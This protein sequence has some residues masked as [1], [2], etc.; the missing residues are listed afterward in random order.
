[1]ITK[2]SL[3]GIEFRCEFFGKIKATTEHPIFSLP[4]TNLLAQAENWAAGKL[5]DTENKLLF[6]ALLKST[7]LVTFSNREGDKAARI[8]PSSQIIFQNMERLMSTCTWISPYSN[9]IS[10]PRF[11]I[12][13][14]NSDLDNI[15]NILD[16][17]ANAKNQIRDNYIAELA[18]E[19]LDN[20][21]V[22]LDRLLQKIYDKPKTY[23][24]IL[25]QWALETANAPLYLRDTWLHM[26]SRTNKS[27]WD[28]ATED[29]EL[30]LEFFETSPVFMETVS[31][32]S[33]KAIATLQH[34]RYL[35]KENQEGFLGSISSFSFIEDETS[36]S[37]LTEAANKVAELTEF[38]RQEQY[39]TKLDFIR[40]K[41]AWQARE[42]LLSNQE[43]VETKLEKSLQKASL[44]AIDNAEDSEQNNEDD[45]NDAR[46]I[47]GITSE[48]REDSFL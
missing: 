41:I 19:Q 3:T 4:L 6:L 46:E 2:C 28:T 23:P 29:Y 5:N 9:L 30:L 12:T 8:N 17:W 37:S 38:P 36:F 44:E 14:L 20:K 7:D 10:F 15:R 40:A 16:A 47:L 25:G 27:L 31:S 11:T 22:A 33:L 43:K 21:A 35:M 34:L 45:Y 42:I 18:R 26:F 1:M 48:V 13:K 39:A 32:G 24:K